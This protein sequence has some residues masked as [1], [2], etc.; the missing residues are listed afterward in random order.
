[1]TKRFIFSIA[2]ALGLVVGSVSAQAEE[3]GLPP[4]GSGVRDQASLQRGAKLFFNYCVGC[5]SLKYVRYS[6]IAEDLGLSEQE[7]MDNLNFTGAKFGETV[8]SHMPEADAQ[9]FFGK[10]P[11]DLS[12]EVRAKTADWV[13]A[14]L[15]SFY[16]DPSRPV[17]WNNTVF[18]NASMPFPL[19]ELQG[20]QTAVK[21]PGSEEVEKLELSRPGKLTPEQYHQAARDLTSFL[22]YASEPAA[23]QRQKYGIWVLLFLA[24]FTLLAYMLKKEYWKDVH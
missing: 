7:V 6:R 19:W 12:L 23:L 1:M 17:G 10:A 22:E 16:L 4:S 5:H 15:N 2:L 9:K 13:Y 3:G 18:P 14:Y 24:G 20:V 21:K 11:P 8:V